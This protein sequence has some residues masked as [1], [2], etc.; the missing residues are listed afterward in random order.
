MTNTNYQKIFL[1]LLFV[2]IEA[3][4]Q[5]DL[6]FSYKENESLM[7]ELL[8]VIKLKTYNK[9]WEM[10]MADEIDQLEYENEYTQKFIG[11]AVSSKQFKELIPLYFTED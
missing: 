9:D 6:I 2:R 8:K 4:E 5:I 10:S 1:E 7:I 11:F 3:S